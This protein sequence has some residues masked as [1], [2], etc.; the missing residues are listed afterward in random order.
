MT[1][2]KAYGQTG[3]TTIY[4]RMPDGRVHSTTVEFTNAPR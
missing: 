3:E 2:V 1:D 4:A